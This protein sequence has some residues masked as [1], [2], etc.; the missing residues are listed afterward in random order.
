MNVQNNKHIPLVDLQAQYKLIKSEIN[1]AIS[2]VVGNC[3]F[4]GGSVVESFENEFAASLS[5]KHVIGVGNG[6]DAI[7]L[8]LKALA[9]GAGDEVIVPANTFIATSEAVT[10]IGAHVVFA[11]CD[12]EDYGI[13]VVDVGRKITSKTKAVIVVHLYGQPAKLSEL[14][15]LAKKHK[16]LLIEDTAQAHL[17]NYKGRTVGTIGDAGTFSFYPGKN[18][19]AYG[20]AG[21]IATNDDALAKRCRMLANHG[22]ID[23][24]DHLIEGYNSRLDAMQA[25]ILSVKLR[26]LTDWTEARRKVA[27]RYDELLADIPE[28][29]LPKKFADRRSVYHLYVVRCKE[30]D[31]LREYLKKTGVESGIHYPIALPFLNAYKHH[32]HIPKDFPVAARFQNELLSLP[33]YP[34]LDVKDQDRIIARIHEFFL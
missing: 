23:K 18:L 29:V 25:A 6:T 19:G 16:L 32:G 10:A 15:A 30:R 22:R 34:E 1:T 9:I 28:L 21:A 24:Y 4:I 12:P 11:D 26:H 8:V 33:I 20:D 31:A 2:G 17:A 3:A 13:D 5:A 7:S 27:L 14:G